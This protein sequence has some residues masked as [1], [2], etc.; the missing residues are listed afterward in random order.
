VG[1]YFAAYLAHLIELMV[2]KKKLSVDFH[3]RMGVH[4]AD[5]TRALELDTKRATAYFNRGNIHLEKGAYAK[6]IGD[7]TRGLAFDP[8]NAHAY[9]GRGSASVGFRVVLIAGAKTP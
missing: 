9:L 6:A 7:Y 4:I 1:T 5:Y 3:F 2:A 8:R